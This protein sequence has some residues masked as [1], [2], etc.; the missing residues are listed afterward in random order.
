[1]AAIRDHCDAKISFREGNLLCS[2]SQK[3]RVKLSSLAIL[4][5]QDKR[6]DAVKEGDCRNDLLEKMYHHCS[7][8]IRKEIPN[9]LI[10]ALAVR[11]MGCIRVDSN[12]R[13]QQPFV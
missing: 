12:N 10:R 11:T 8:M 3:S 2:I 9:P 13:G 7:Q 1:M 4:I 6:K 5:K